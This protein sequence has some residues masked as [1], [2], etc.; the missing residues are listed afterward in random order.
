VPNLTRGLVEVYT[1][2]AKGK[3]TAAFGLALRAA[4]HGFK[5]RII[6]FMKQGT[7]GENEA[8][9][10]LAPEVEIYSFGRKGFIHRGGARPQDFDLAREAL[11]CARRF[12]LDSETDVLILDELNNALYFGLLEWE[13]IKEFIA[14]KP[15][16][17]EL[18]I[19]GRNAPPEMV[20]MADL[21]TE[22]LEIKH[23]YSEGVKSR[24]GI[25]Y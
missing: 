6:Q 14:Q 18:V 21:V 24:K 1:G 4:G 19:T 2:N 7:Y 5:V 3:S 8:F 16:Q 23:P 11:D 20:A 15:E 17:M 9:K 22:M 12:L 25:E 13:E 10:R